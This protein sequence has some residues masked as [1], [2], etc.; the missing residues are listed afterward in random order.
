MP[1]LNIA[2]LQADLRWED[3]TAN[4][5]HFGQLLEQVAPETDLILMP[6]T[7]TTAF[8]V[9]PK[10]FAETEEDPTMQWLKNQAQ[11][12]NAVICATFPLEKDGHYYNSLVWMRPDGTYELYFKRHTFTMG[13]EDQLVDRGEKQ[14]I[15]ELKG[16]R[17]KPM[18]CYD[19]RFPI[20]ARNR[21]E[22]GAYEYDL[23]FYLAN[24]PDSRMNVWNT[25]LQARAI[26][27]QAYFI[28][29]NRVGEDAHG[30]HYSGESQVINA[31][32]EVIS[33]A[34]PY[35]E[36]VLHCTLDGEKLQHFREKFPLG[37]D[38]DKFDLRHIK[39]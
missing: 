34:E 33:K 7:F 4:L 21:Y 27:N 14:L 29:V 13:G 25:L 37:P 9:N 24:F 36:A 12:K 17:I 11:S 32:G 8:P 15:V 38:W 1:N 31:R 30:L 35:Q 10:V 16:W 18:V 22:N 23:G 2:Y 3:K 19:I 5:T 26:E 28:G 6:E 39:P 20:W